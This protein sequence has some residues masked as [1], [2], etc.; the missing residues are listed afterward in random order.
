MPHSFSWRT[1]ALVCA[2]LTAPA[3]A[4]LQGWTYWQL[5]SDGVETLG[6]VT[7][8]TV[9]RGNRTTRYEVK[10]RFKDGLGRWRSGSQ[11]VRSAV[12]DTLAEGRQ[13]VVVYSPS[14]PEA[15]AVSMESLHDFVAYYAIVSFGIA[16]VAGCAAWAWSFVRA[17]RRWQLRDAPLDL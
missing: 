12:F 3:L 15:N 17:H 11:D 4:F 10:Y 6:V 5:A 1:L 14:H 2:V 8:K 9:Y 16:I 7:D 13:T